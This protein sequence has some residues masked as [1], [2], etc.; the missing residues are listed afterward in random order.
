MA[1]TLTTLFCPHCD[2][3]IEILGEM[4]RPA[5]ECEAC[6]GVLEPVEWSAAN[7]EIARRLTAD[8]AAQFP[9]ASGREG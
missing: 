5:P 2:D 8:F 1:V 7:P 6:G 9:V 4:P 3:V